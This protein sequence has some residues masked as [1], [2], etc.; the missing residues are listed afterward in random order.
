MSPGRQPVVEIEYISGAARVAS[1]ETQAAADGFGYYIANPNLALNGVDTQGFAGL[2]P[3]PP[4]PPT[5]VPVVAI[6]IFI[7]VQSFVFNNISGCT[8]IS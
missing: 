7:F 3:P 1:V 2:T 6:T 5:A 8:F 4:T